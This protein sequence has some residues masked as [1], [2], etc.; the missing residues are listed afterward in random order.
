MLVSITNE[1]ALTDSLAEL[2]SA[3]PFTAASLPGGIQAGPFRVWPGY[4]LKRVCISIAVTV[5]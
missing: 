3:M 1:S 4:F 5:R 2:S